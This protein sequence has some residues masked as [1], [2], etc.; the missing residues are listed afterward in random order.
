MK[1]RYLILISAWCISVSTAFAADKNKI[2]A[3]LEATRSM[4]ETVAG[5]TEGNREAAADLDQA[6]NALRYADDSFKAGKSMF[7]FGDLTPEAEKEIKISLD[8]AERATATALSRIEYVR[9][10]A[11]LEAI[12]KQFAVVTGK[13]K[14]FE[15]RKAEMERLRGEEIKCQVISKELETIKAEKTALVSQVEQL[16]GE[17]NRADKLKIEQ[18]ELSRTVDELKTENARLTALQEKQTPEIKTAP[19]TAPV[20]DDQ[21]KTIKK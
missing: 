14:L 1:W 10:T 3:Q 13:L 5:K 19:V 15:E 12:E 4:V 17:R 7:G 20:P 2:S 16:S 18:L 21:K 8:T 9:A 6:R 11:E